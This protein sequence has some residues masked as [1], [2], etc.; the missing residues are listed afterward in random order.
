LTYN[1][2]LS[3]YLIKFKKALKAIKLELITKKTVKDSKLSL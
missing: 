1:K 2:E 3:L